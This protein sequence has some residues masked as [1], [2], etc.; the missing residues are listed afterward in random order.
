M[1]PRYRDYA[2]WED[3]ASIHWINGEKEKTLRLMEE[4]RRANPTIKSARTYKARRTPP[5]P[6]CLCALCGE[7]TML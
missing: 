5:P 2:V 1:E 6:L 7:I 3:L 4:L